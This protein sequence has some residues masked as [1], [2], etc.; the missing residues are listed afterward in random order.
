MF[1]VSLSAVVSRVEGGQDFSHHQRAFSDND[2]YSSD[3]DLLIN[4]DDKRQG[5]SNLDVLSHQP[6]GSLPVE[7]PHA[8]GRHGSCG[9]Q[10]GCA[11]A[12]GGNGLM[13]DGF[14]KF[15]ISQ[16][17]GKAKRCINIL[18]SPLVYCRIVK[19]LHL[20]SLFGIVTLPVLT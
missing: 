3:R 4:T 1:P 2:L 12:T 18:V 19:K 8:G 13:Y 17:I 20:R 16:I 10:R 14:Y 7:D 9:S 6:L 11:Q 15:S 5:V